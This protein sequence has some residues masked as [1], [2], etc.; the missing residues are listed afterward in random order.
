ML[1]M[2]E[3][4]DSTGNCPKDFV[5]FLRQMFK[6]VAMSLYTFSNLL[7]TNHQFTAI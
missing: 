5:D 3:V 7:F 1:H 2:Q 6:A 4:S